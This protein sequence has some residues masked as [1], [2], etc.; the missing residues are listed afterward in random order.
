M[1]AAPPS[2]ALETRPF[3]KKRGPGEPGPKFR[4]ETPKKGCDIR[5]KLNRC[6]NAQDTLRCTKNKSDN[7]LQSGLFDA[8]NFLQ[9]I[10]LKKIFYIHLS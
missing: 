10:V 2:K 6:R 7:L 5:R 3:G 9:L 4:E 8:G 1:H